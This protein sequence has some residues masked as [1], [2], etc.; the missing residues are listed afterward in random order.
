MNRREA[1]RRVA[2]LT[3]AAVSM[4]LATAI[5]QGC[6]SEPSREGLK[7]L[8]A[9]QYDVFNELAE[10]IIPKTDTPGAKDVGV[11][12]FIDTMLAEFYP[13][14]EAKKYVKM[15]DEFEAACE[16]ANGK[17]FLDMKDDERDTYL[18]KV[19]AEA[20]KALEGGKNGDELFW[21]TAKQGVLS[22]FFITE[23][24]AR[25]VLQYKDIPG[26]F[27]GCVPL[28]DAGEGRTWA[29]V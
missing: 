12:D 20:H 29:S 28:K 5:L 21:F 17:S 11:T 7:Y 6:Q 22:A 19:E 24:G 9:K 16:K 23:A 25:Q 14:A 18:K 26:P 13:E 27:Q 15:I 8:S 10:R 4:P 2:L 3:G 1:L